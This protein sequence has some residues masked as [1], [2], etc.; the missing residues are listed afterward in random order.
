MG[1]LNEGLGLVLGAPS[2]SH[3]C[4]TA[5]T[6]GVLHWSSSNPQMPTKAL[7]LPGTGIEW[8][9]IGSYAGTWGYLNAAQEI[10]DQTAGQGFTDVALVRSAQN[11]CTKSAFKFIVVQRHGCCATCAC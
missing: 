8:G 3:S 1:Q 4:S 9:F 7:P 10:L 11:P 2:S 6:C 5:L